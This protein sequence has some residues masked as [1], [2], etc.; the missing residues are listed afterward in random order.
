MERRRYD[1][2]VRALFGGLGPTSYPAFARRRRLEG[3][4]V[5][6]FTIGRSGALLAAS[7]SRPAPHAVLDQAALDAVR[8]LAFPPAPDTVAGASF[9]YDVPVVFQLSSKGAGGP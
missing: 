5:I 9:T 4:V 3:T 2:T 8:S 6:H 1:S 7:V